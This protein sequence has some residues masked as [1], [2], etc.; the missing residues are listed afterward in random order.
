[1]KKLLAVRTAQVKATPHKFMRTHDYIK[2]QIR[3]AH[4]LGAPVK[5]ETVTIIFGKNG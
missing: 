2:S 1:M 3:K 4:A 5:Q